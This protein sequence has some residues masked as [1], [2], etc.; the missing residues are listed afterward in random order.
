VDDS[1][2]SSFC[3]YFICTSLCLSHTFHVFE[4][5]SL[6]SITPSFARGGDI[7]EPYLVLGILIGFRFQ[8]V[9]E[10]TSQ[11]LQILSDIEV[12]LT[13]SSYGKYDF[14]NFIFVKTV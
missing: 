12:V 14:R 7:M 8:Y 3:L 5:A 11:R 10:L 2:Y 4:F 9:S 13:K 1:I 6:I